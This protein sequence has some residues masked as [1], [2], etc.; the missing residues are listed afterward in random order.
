MSLYILGYSHGVFEGILAVFR[1]L[2]VQQFTR[3]PYV[4]PTLCLYSRLCVV[5]AC[6]VV[7]DD[8][9]CTT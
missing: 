7:G 2:A 1:S 8:F 4:V 6:K 9:S 3:S 5:A